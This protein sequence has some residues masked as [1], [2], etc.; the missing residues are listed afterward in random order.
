MEGPKQYEF[1]TEEIVKKGEVTIYSTEEDMRKFKEINEY[2]CYMKV[3]RAKMM[4]LKQ[5]RE[6]YLLCDVIVVAALIFT[7]ILKRAVFLEKTLMCIVLLSIYIV[8]CLIL[9]LLKSELEI[10]S[11][12]LITGLLL[13]ID[14]LF[15]ILLVMNIVFCLIYRI[16]KGRL[17]EEWGYPL[18][19]D[20]RIDRIRNRN[21]NEE[22][23]TTMYS[24]IVKRK[25][26]MK[27][28]DEE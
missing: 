16:K 20:L 24:D 18:F 15:V 4:E 22:V 9:P 8:V 7:L 13:F 10:I 25:W 19:Y 14:W 12:A 21:Y 23:K 28:Y 3:C 6:T 1:I 2:N 11:N 5:I 26:H 27:D 17:G